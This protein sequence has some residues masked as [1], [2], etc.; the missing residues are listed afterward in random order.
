MQTVIVMV[1]YDW[2]QL[3]QYFSNRVLWN[4]SVPQNIATGPEKNCGI[5]TQLPLNTV[6]I[7]TVPLNISR[8]FVRQLKIL[9]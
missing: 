2:Y 9:E 5:C 1:T 3:D 6:K 7:I 8:I 4:L